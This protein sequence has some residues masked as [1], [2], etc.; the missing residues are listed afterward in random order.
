MHLRLP[1][2]CRTTFCAS[3]LDLTFQR[4]VHSTHLRCLVFRWHRI[5]RFTF[6]FSQHLP[7]PALLLWAPPA[8]SHTCGLLPKCQRNV[9]LMVTFVPASL[10][11]DSFRSQLELFQ[12]LFCSLASSLLSERL[13]SIKSTVGSDLGTLL[14]PSEIIFGSCE[15]LLLFRYELPMAPNSLSFSDSDWKAIGLPMPGMAESWVQS[16]GWWCK[17][18]LRKKHNRSPDAWL[19][20]FWAWATAVPTFFNTVSVPSISGA[21]SGDWRAH[22]VTQRLIRIHAVLARVTTLKYLMHIRP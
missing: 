12:P 21:K 22:C 4:D 5:P 2:T 10:K 13:T 9:R 1:E 3:V 17:C 15:F 11:T 18:D 14:N 8:G 16:V 20:I 19:G 7:L 6:L